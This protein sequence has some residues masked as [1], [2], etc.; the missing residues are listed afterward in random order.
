MTC[1]L[2]HID[3][4]ACSYQDSDSI[5]DSTFLSPI[6]LSHYSTFLGY[7][8]CLLFHLKSYE[9]TPEVPVGLTS[10]S[11]IYVHIRV[12]PSGQ[13]AD[14]NGFARGTSRRVM[15]AMWPQKDLGPRDMPLGRQMGAARK[16][17]LG[18]AR[19]FIRRAKRGCVE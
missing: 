11:V 15:N 16:W 2:L 8:R 12:P 14:L 9:W 3:R 13:I 18:K 7:V 17:Q 5:A 19:P 1:T 10:V 4:A 6:Q